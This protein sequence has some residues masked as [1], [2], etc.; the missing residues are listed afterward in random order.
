LIGSRYRQSHVARIV[1]N[2]IDVLSTYE[3]HGLGWREWPDRVFYTL[4]DGQVKSLSRIWGRAAAYSP[5]CFLRLYALGGPGA[6]AA[7]S[8]DRRVAH[9]ASR[10]LAVK[11]Q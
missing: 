4:D 8:A 9:R 2:V 6:S 10:T 5:R 1:Q 11:L 7:G 3:N